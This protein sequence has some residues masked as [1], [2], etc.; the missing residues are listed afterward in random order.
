M[1]K[2]TALQAEIPKMMSLLSA[3]AK[4]SGL[5]VRIAATNS[6]RCFILSFYRMLPNR[7]EIGSFDLWFETWGY[8]SGSDPQIETVK[9]TPDSRSAPTRRATAKIEI[10]AS[11]DIL[12]DAFIARIIAGALKSE[13]YRRDLKKEEREASER[14]SENQRILKSMTDELTS[15]M[16]DK[17]E[18]SASGNLVW[19]K[20]NRQQTL[21]V[22]LYPEIKGMVVERFAIESI[23]KLNELVE[24][25]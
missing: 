3:N 14:R 1:V 21:T 7:E 4:K 20:L 18:V 22:K 19:I 6:A 16:G 10:K 17:A 2:R 23:S 11:N 12:T 15:V 8:S 13:S 9:V 25:L 24:L 5:S